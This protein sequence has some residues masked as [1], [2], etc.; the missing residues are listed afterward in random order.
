MIIGLTGS[1]ASGK[2]VFSDFLKEK[3]F[4]YF[5]H[6]DELRKIAKELD[7]EITRKNLQYLGNKIRKERG[8][9]YLTKVIIGKINKMQC[10]KVVIDSIRNPA[11][12]DYLSK[13]KNFFL[14]AVDAPQ[15]LRFK[16]LISRARESDPTTW[17][18]FLEVDNK[19][20]GINE[21]KHGQGVGKC[22]KKSRFI[23]VNDNEGPIE[24]LHPRMENLYADL[25]SKVSRPTWDEYFLEISRSVAKRATCNRGKTGCVIAKNKQILV[26]GYVGSP[27]G[28]PHCDEVGHQLESTIHEDGI[29]RDHCIRTTHAE[30]NAICQAAKLGIPIK[31]ATLYCKMVPCPVCAKMIANAGIKRVVCEKGYQSG[32]ADLMKQAGILV[33]VLDREIEKY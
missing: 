8:L 16:R 22:I 20:K 19:D 1:L 12:V 26:T 6:S 24:L 4:V 33:E 2:G 30:Q 27:T 25:N 18:R 21:E 3:G 10:P 29:K 17:E 15:K 11:E 7:L 5:S 31:G 9:D 32:A 23:F 13:Q 28:L 14:V